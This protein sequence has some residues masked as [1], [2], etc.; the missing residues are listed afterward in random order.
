MNTDVKNIGVKFV[1]KIC[2][3]VIDSSS[4]TDLV[5]QL[6]NCVDKQ[7]RKY[8]DVWPDD[9]RDYIICRCKMWVGK[10]GKIR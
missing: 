5:N 6:E 9:V 7:L 2:N 1:D 4:R 8:N 10:I 3:D